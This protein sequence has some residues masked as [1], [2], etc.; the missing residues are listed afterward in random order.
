[1]NCEFCS[2]KITGRKKRYCNPKCNQAHYYQTISKYKQKRIF[3]LCKCGG[4]KQITST[5]CRK[6]YSLNK[7][8]GQVSRSILK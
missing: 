3:D 5:K 1:M 8:K 4:Q 7:H 6:C 2:K